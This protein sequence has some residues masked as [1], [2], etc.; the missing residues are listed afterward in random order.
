MADLV[1]ELMDEKPLSKVETKRLQELEGVIE[2]NFRGFVLVG[3]ALAEI[4]DKRLYRRSHKT[5]EEYCNNI[6]DVSR[7]RAYQLIDSSNVV[8]NLSTI[9]DK[10][11]QDCLTAIADKIPIDDTVIFPRNE[12]QARELAKLAPEKQKEVW[13]QIVEEARETGK[14][15]TAK[16]I[17]KKV[18]TFTGEIV[19]KK[20]EDARAPR[21]TRVDFKSE[22]FNAAF[23]HL[24]EVVKK[25]A[26]SNWRTTSRKTAYREI[27]AILD[28]VSLAPP[29][30]LEIQGC[31]MELSDREKLQKAGFR[32]FRM[33][34]RQKLIEEWHTRD[35]W[36]FYQEHEN[37]KALLTAFQE[38]MKDY[39]HLKG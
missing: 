7:P 4:R 17:K 35:D 31:T 12:A 5:F 11:E 23:D 1:P 2:E 24:F 38:L 34:T 21:E 9:V 8:K 18:K 19:K 25:E 37:P 15:I 14:P 3:M 30:S 39:T 27:R 33:N 10:E 29:K 28:V 32:I 20:V 6:W 26:E 16:A 13:L 36:V 22:E